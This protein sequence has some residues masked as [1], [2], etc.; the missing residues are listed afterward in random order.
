M[1]IMV[2][3]DRGAGDTM[4][5]EGT[6]GALNACRACTP[7]CRTASLIGVDGGFPEGPDP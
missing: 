5:L 2:A 4:A 1:E 7:D 3:A 6:R